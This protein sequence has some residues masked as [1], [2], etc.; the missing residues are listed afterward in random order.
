MGK[1]IERAVIA[2]LVLIAVVVVIGMHTTWRD[3]TA[4]GGT[5]VRGL[6]SLECIK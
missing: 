5:T 6:F 1:W 4:A 3:C 2:V